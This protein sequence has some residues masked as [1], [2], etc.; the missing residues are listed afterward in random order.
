MFKISENILE[1]LNVILDMKFL[2]IDVNRYIFIV[3]LF[4]VGLPLTK[5]TAKVLNR[6]LTHL[7]NY[8]EP[9]SKKISFDYPILILS[10]GLYLWLVPLILNFSDPTMVFFTQAAKLFLYLAFITGGLTFANFIKALL[11]QKAKNTD[12]KFD[13]LLAPL[14]GTLLKVGIY[15]IGGISIA[16]ILGLPLASL[17]AGV[18]VG[19]IAIAM[20]AKDSIQ[21]IIG[22]VT[23]VIDKS[24][25]IG[26][27]IK[28]GG[29]EGTVEYLG[30]RSTRIRTFYNSVITIPNSMFLNAEIDN[31][32]LREYRR[33]STKIGVTY[34]TKAEDIEAFCE[35][36]RELLRL[37]PRTR[38]DYFFVYFNSMSDSSLEI[39]LYCFFE[40]PDW[41]VE[42]SARHRLLLD[43]VRLANKLNIDFAFPT[44]TLFMQR[45]TGSSDELVPK[46]EVFEKMK[47]AQ[48]N[49]DIITKKY[50]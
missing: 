5:F 19:G 32:G 37:H 25:N 29:N 10:C 46:E 1:S 9:N 48:E 42:L 50:H 23:I 44:Q 18:G 24:F 11:V 30:L 16:E 27:W 21:S 13:D 34:Q 15:L 45:D 17:I 40:V 8:G 6:I 2:G 31:M 12:R 49:A 41:S 22:F 36:I 33:F 38:K 47:L 20:A 26:D 28:V 39:L 43:I 14:I 7:N 3:L 35:G 4:I